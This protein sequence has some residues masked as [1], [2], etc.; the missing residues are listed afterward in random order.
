LNFVDWDKNF[1]SGTPQDRLFVAL[2]LTHW[3]QDVD[4][5]A[6]VRLIADEVKEVGK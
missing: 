1:A 6:L 3:Q 4:D 5:R 2:T